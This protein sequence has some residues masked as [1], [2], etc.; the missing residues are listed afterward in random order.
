MFMMHSKKENAISH[1]RYIS[2]DKTFE[3]KIILNII[4][5]ISKLYD[6]LRKMKC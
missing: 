1:V 6:S 5:N 4:L 3:C 2:E